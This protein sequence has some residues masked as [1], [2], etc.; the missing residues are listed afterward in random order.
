MGSIGR[1]ILVIAN[2]LEEHVCVAVIHVDVDEMEEVLDLGHTQLVVFVLVRFPQAAE[3]PAGK[4]IVRKVSV[5]R[6]LSFLLWTDKSST[7]K[8][9]LPH[10]WS[11]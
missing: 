3:D 5:C 2:N 4:F 9:H 6:A 7:L 1:K 8:I 11:R 10:I